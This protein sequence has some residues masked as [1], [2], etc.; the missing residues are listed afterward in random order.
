[1]QYSVVSSQSLRLLK[2]GVLKLFLLFTF[3]SFVK[4][5][6]QFEIPKKPDFQTSVYDYV[7]LLSASEKSTLENKLVKYSDSTSTQIV[8]AVIASTKGEYINYLATEWAHEWGIGQA[9]EDNGVF[10][11]LARDDR[12]IMIATGYG[13]EHLLTDAMSRRIIE[14]DIIPYFKRNDYYGGLNR[15]SDAIFEVLKGE[16]K[17]TRQS[18]G[19]DFPVGV[20][21]FLIIIF[22]IILIS[23]SKHKRNGGNGDNFGGG[24]NDTRDILEAIILSNSGRGGYRRSSGG[25]GGGFGGSSGGGFGSGGFGGGFGGGGFGGGGASGGW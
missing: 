24:R 3:L 21:F 12:K 6:A 4:V 16:Y 13:V 7:N 8:V 15:G 20:I 10:I 2:K 18:S 5:S 14:R 9:K 23:I 11:L 19:G 25:F 22:I 17:G 1:M